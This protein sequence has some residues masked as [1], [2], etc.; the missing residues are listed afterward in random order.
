MLTRP[1]QDT[2][3]PGQT[4]RRPKKK[5]IQE[6]VSCY[7]R[8]SFLGL[9]RGLSARSPQLVD[10]HAFLVRHSWWTGARFSFTTVG[11]RVTA[12]RLVVEERVSLCHRLPGSCIRLYCSGNRT[13]GPC[14]IVYVFMATFRVQTGL[15]HTSVDYTDYGG[16]NGATYPGR[17]EYNTRTTGM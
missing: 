5:T 6:Q 8:R 11:G 3:P 10:G 17:S 16:P 9:V 14:R 15:T 12:C 7:I 13:P 4:K 1:E 2:D